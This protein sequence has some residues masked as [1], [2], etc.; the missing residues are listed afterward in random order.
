MKYFS[1]KVRHARFVMDAGLPAR[2]WKGWQVKLFNRAKAFD[3]YQFSAFGIEDLCDM[4]EEIGRQCRGYSEIKRPEWDRF[5][6]LG[7]CPRIQIGYSCYIRFLQ[8][9]GDYV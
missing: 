4:L 3:N 7:I 2:S 1:E 9:K 5:A 8:I 6:D